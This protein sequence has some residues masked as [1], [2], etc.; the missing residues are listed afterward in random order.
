[1][2]FTSWCGSCAWK[3]SETPSAASKCS[4]ALLPSKHSRIFMFNDG[5][6]SKTTQNLI[7]LREFVFVLF[8]RAFDV[9]MLYIA[10]YFRM[11]MYEVDINWEE[12]DGSKLNVFSY[13]Q[14]GKDLLLIRLH[15]MLGIWKLDADLRHKLD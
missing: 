7:K 5:K 13:V 10:N 6:T 14:M 12:R 9:D 1:M 8:S 4:H 15:Y 11:K 2:D 3:V